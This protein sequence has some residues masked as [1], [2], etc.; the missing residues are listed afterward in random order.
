M[1]CEACG[2]DN[3]RPYN[4]IRR[5][6]QLMEKRKVSCKTTLRDI[7]K[8][9]HK[10]IPSDKSNQ[11][12]YYFLQAISKVP[13]TS[14][15]HYVSRYRESEY[16]YQGKGFAYLKKMIISGYENEPKMLENEIRKFGRTPA[17][18]KV[19]KG[20]YKNVYTNNGGDSI[21]S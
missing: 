1:K 4:P 9:I 6:I 13:D 18:K 10:Q 20:E 14:V 11:K 15:Q 12:T 19:E 2:Y 8:L 16:V 7:C 21:S 17:K 5:I 3:V